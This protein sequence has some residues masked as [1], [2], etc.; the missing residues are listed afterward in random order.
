[1][2]HANTP[3][4]AAEKTSSPSRAG[5]LRPLRPLSQ[6][7][8]DL[9]AQW[10]AQQNAGMCLDDYTA[11]SLYRAW[12][13]CPR[14]HHWQA[15][16][17]SRCRKRSGCR[18]C[19]LA[20]RLRHDRSFDHRRLSRRSPTLAAGWH[21]TRNG[22]L[23]PDDITFSS[24]VRVWWICPNVPT[25]VWNTTVNNRQRS[26]CPYCAGRYTVGFR[27]RKRETRPLAKTHEKL[28]KLWHPTLNGPLTPE[29]VTAGSKRVVWWMCPH[30]PTHLRRLSVYRRTHFDVVC[31]PCR[32]AR[33]MVRQVRRR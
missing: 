5:R 20:D 10:D 2:P 4:S 6:R 30:D 12:W 29:D 32:V 7:R 9:L 28:A 16:I 17:R 33:R 26:G 25:H 15:T 13:I 3:I 22:L 1:M 18:R 31:M 19:T 14:Q 23:T 8:P 24:R 21:P 27:P 11:D